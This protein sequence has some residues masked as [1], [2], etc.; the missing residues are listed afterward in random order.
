MQPI[1]LYS[2]PGTDAVV[3]KDDRGEIVVPEGWAIDLLKQGI[4]LTLRGL[5]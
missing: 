1:E 4:K 3:L 5:L 2:I